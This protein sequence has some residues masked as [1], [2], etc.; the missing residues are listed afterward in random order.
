MGAREHP[1]AIEERLLGA[2]AAN[3]REQRQVVQRSRQ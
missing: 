2:V 3:G 1:R